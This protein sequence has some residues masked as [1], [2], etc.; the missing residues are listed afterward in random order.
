MSNEKRSS[1]NTSI[2]E[3]Q[4]SLHDF[5]SRLPSLTKTSN[6]TTAGNDV[7]A[8]GPVNIDKVRHEFKQQIDQLRSICSQFESDVGDMMSAG[9]DPAFKKHF[10]QLKDQATLQSTVLLIDQQL[11]QSA[12]CLDKALNNKPAYSAQDKADQLEKLAKSMGLVSFIDTSQQ[13]ELGKSVT[14]ITLGGTAI[15][16]DIDIQS[17]GHVQRAK[18]TFVPE[19]L[20]N[21]Q[22]EKLD[23]LLTSHLQENHTSR[24]KQNLEMLALLDRLN[25]AHAPMD[26]FVTVRHLFQDLKTITE[27]ESLQVSNQ[28]SQVL[29]EGH[30]IPCLNLSSPGIAIT[31]W[32][33]QKTLKT[34]DWDQ[35]AKDME[36]NKRPLGLLPACSL[37]IGFEASMTQRQYLPP[38]RSSYLVDFQEAEETILHDGSGLKI[39]HEPKSPSFMPPL[40]FVKPSSATTKA[41]TIPVRFVAKLPT[42]LPASDTVIQKIMEMTGMANKKE[43][44]PVTV[45]LERSSALSLEELLIHGFLVDDDKSAPFR[46]TS[47]TWLKTSDES[48]DQQYEWLA[49]T[50]STGKLI[51]RIPFQ[52]PAQLF[53]IVQVLRQQHMFNDLFHTLFNDNTYTAGKKLAKP[54]KSVSLDHILHS[55]F[56]L[57]HRTK[58]RLTFFLLLT[59]WN[60]GARR[61]GATCRSDK[62]ECA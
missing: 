62:R 6:A 50:G 38:E 49:Y 37:I 35:V 32:M 45:P 9:T 56:C 61:T 15:V 2:F 40:R 1:I 8:F 7:H 19:H 39:I 25:V 36:Q 48:L 13:D 43:S 17:G 12:S 28:L 18:V 55:K 44:M 23:S 54:N 52:H 46:S 41:P 51:H 33:T 21:D 58:T 16:I 14:T 42:P 59:D 29:M 22:D 3:V 4:N 57:T 31:Y 11:Q 27:Q 53:G 30:G 10:T 34:C 47:L 5:Q 20:Q 60:S 26:F 24:F